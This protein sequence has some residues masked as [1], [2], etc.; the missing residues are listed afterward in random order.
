MCC[1]LALK[2][3]CYMMVASHGRFSQNG[4]GGCGCDVDADAFEDASGCVLCFFLL[5]FF[6]H[7]PE[8]HP[9]AQTRDCFSWFWSMRVVLCFVLLYF[10]ISAWKGLCGFAF[11]CSLGLW[12]SNWSHSATHWTKNLF[13]AL[14]I[15]RHLNISTQ[16]LLKKAELNDRECQSYFSIILLLE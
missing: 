12:S 4:C 15:I 10:A 3:R 16:F 2:S 11:V 6:E 1:L 5:L 13:A 9:D 14:P 8:A 7:H